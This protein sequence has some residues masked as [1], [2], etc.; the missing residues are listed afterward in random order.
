MGRRKKQKEIEQK[1]KH[2]RIIEKYT[3]N[4]NVD[5]FTLLQMS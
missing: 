2:L 4:G 3:G 1:K 5:R